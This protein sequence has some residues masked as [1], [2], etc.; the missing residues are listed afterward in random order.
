MRPAFNLH[1]RTDR[2]H[3]SQRNHTEAQPFADHDY[4]EEHR[5]NI[6]IDFQ[7]KV[8]EIKQMRDKIAAFPHR[9]TLYLNYKASRHK[10]NRETAEGQR[11]EAASPQGKK[12]GVSNISISCLFFQEDDQAKLTPFQKD[13]ISKMKAKKELMLWKKSSKIVP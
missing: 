11:V 5:R 2:Q 13:S 12:I 8:Q 3:L 7:K 9:K 1:L 6:I 4:L 10:E